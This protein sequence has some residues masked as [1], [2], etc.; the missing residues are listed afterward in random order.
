MRITSLQ[1]PSAL[2][3]WLKNAQKVFS[4]EKS[5]LRLMALSFSGLRMLG[6]ELFKD[7]AD[8]LEGLLLKKSQLFGKLLLG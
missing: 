1:P 3:T 5:L 7:L 4:L 2:S 8:L 6:D